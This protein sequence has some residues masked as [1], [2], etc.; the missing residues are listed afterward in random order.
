MNK[1]L[2]PP[3]FDGRRW[4]NAGEDRIEIVEA[5][6]DWP[7]RYAEEVEV[8][9]AEFRRRGI[10]G[11]VFEHI[12]S[13]AVAGLPA[14]PVIDILALAPPALDWQAL[15][16]PLEALGYR[17]WRENPAKQRMFFVK[18]MPPYGSG[19]S[20]HLHLMPQEEAAQRLG[21]RDWLR[22]HPDDAHAY[23]TLKRR[24][25][26]NHYSDREAYTRG[27]D[28]FIA[29]ILQLASQGRGGQGT[30]GDR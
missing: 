18:G 24:L 12:G 29:A 25:A 15:V 6:A 28:A 7:R 9:G 2:R 21:F 8:I 20:H 3:T 10:E 4:S 5:R 16:E 23:A 14:K 19:R 17:Y 1:S 26:D 13:T 30:E 27:K 22:Q 11:V